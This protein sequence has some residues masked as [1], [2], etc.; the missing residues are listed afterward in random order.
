M[1]GIENGINDLDVFQPLINLLACCDICKLRLR[2]LHILWFWCRS[3]HSQLL[4]KSGQCDIQPDITCGSVSLQDLTMLQPLI[5][6]LIDQ[7]RSSYLQNGSHLISD[8]IPSASGP[9][10]KLNLCPF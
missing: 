4:C 7:A 1:Y 8:T 5:I 3:R 6:I 2:Y 9:R 10:R